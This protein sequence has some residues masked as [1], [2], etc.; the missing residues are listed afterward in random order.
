MFKVRKVLKIFVR[1]RVSALP[2]NTPPSVK[3]HFWGIF[4]S[5]CLTELRERAR[6]WRVGSRV[7][8]AVGGTGL[9][10]LAAQARRCALAGIKQSVTLSDQVDLFYSSWLGE[11][12]TIT[13]STTL[14]T[15]TAA[16]R[17][18]ASSSLASASPCSGPPPA[19][20]APRKPRPSSTRSATS[21]S[22]E[23]GTFKRRDRTLLTIF[24]ECTDAWTRVAST[25]DD[26]SS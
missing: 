6:G 15:V 5:G 26:I 25:A 19:A 16:R 9:R 22:F 17:P 13:A 12:S 23:F 4:R 21:T 14:S 20:P 24:A 7:A 18:S 10:A 1:E 8:A 3:T 11:G 2:R